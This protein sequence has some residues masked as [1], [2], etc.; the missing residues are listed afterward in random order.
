MRTRAS[1]ASFKSSVPFPVAGRVVPARAM[2][3]GR[4]FSDFPLDDDDFKEF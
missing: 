4:D 1:V 3:G 2:P